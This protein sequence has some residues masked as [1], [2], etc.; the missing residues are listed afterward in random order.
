MFPLR[1]LASFPFD[2]GAWKSLQIRLVSCALSNGSPLHSTPPYSYLQAIWPH[3]FIS[4]KETKEKYVP[5]QLRRKPR[6]EEKWR[7]GKKFAS[8]IMMG[9]LWRDDFSCCLV[10][11]LVFALNWCTRRL[12]KSSAFSTFFHVGFRSPASLPNSM[13]SC[14]S[15]WWIQSWWWWRCSCYEFALVHKNVSVYVCAL[16]MCTSQHDQDST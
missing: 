7:T 4:V 12:S 5:T 13:G 14:C 3:S 11:G 10:L 8:F 1:F 6:E 15:R 16:C 2:F 9:H